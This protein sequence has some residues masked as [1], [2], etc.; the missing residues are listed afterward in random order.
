MPDLPISALVDK[1][2]PDTADQIV[3]VDSVSGQS[4]RTS[5]AGLLA[6]F[7]APYGPRREGQIS[8]DPD[9]PDNPNGVYETWAEVLAAAAASSAD[10]LFVNTP[11]SAFGAGNSPL[12]PDGTYSL[13]QAGTQIVPGDQL[14]A[15]APMS[16]FEMGAE[17]YL[18]D[19]TEIRRATF[20]S[21]NANQ[22]AHHF[23]AGDTD[24]ITFTAA[25]QIEGWS[26]NS[27]PIC[28]FQPGATFG[29]LKAIDQS[30][31]ATSRTYALVPSGFTFIA[32]VQGDGGWAEDVL[33]GAG[34]AI[35][36]DRS[37]TN[38]VDGDIF[39][40]PRITGTVQ[41]RRQVVSSRIAWGDPEGG[42]DAASLRGA[43]LQVASG[44]AKRFM[45]RYDAAGFQSLP[46][47]VSTALDFPNLSSE[48]NSAAMVTYAPG[49]GLWTFQGA[50]ELA[51]WG[52]CVAAN[53]QG[54]RTNLDLTVEI[55]SGGGFV[56]VA[57]GASASYHRNT[58]DGRDATDADTAIFSVSDGDIMRVV[59]I[60]RVSNCVTA[61]NGTVLNVESM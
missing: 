29:L 24:T 39:N 49:T 9:N 12:I 7:D 26:A 33:S 21:D 41:D 28:G 47:G 30:L 37:A 19:L 11:N 27:A 57:G 56:P 5:L 34:T 42:I 38:V 22:A 31:T 50:H 35:I 1:P 15:R 52:K 58:S 60:P 61:P 53:T 3:L 14:G 59:V 55:D 36:I 43:V 17:V 44:A 16:Y 46:A 4:R 54:G 20:R 25:S 32:D 10:V 51:V 45:S 48:R 23:E 13:L 6:L 18:T 40:Q 8:W 2:T